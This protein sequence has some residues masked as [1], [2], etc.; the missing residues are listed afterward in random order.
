VRDGLALLSE[1]R[2]AGERRVHA[3]LLALQ[4]SAR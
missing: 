1:P 2:Y 4:A 3:Q